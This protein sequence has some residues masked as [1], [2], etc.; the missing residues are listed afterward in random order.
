MFSL[1]V[2]KTAFSRT[3]ARCVSSHPQIPAPI[4]CSCKHSVLLQIKHLG[5][6]SSSQKM[7][8]TCEKLPFCAVAGAALAEMIFHSCLAMTKARRDYCL[9][10]G[11]FLLIPKENSKL[12]TNWGWILLI[13]SFVCGKALPDFLKQ[14]RPRVEHVGQCP[15]CP[16]AGLHFRL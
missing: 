5:L 2:L 13:Q 14:P 12:F 15:C 10:C 6:K 1:K 9:F 16:W 11:S 4:S 8:T 3:L 7:S